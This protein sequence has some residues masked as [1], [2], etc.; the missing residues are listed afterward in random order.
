M[1]YRVHLA[2]KEF[3]TKFDIYVLIT[4]SRR[5][6][7]VM[8]SWHVFNFSVNIPGDFEGPLCW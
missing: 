8:F 6:Q 1:L 4:K 2:M 5:I 3:D 7:S